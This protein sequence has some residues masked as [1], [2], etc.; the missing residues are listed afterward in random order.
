MN[1]ML[2]MRAAYNDTPIP[3]EGSSATKLIWPEVALETVPSPTN[4]PPPYAILVPDTT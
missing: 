3:L 2:S 4:R 1:T